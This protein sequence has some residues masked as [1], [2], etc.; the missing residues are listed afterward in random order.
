MK[1]MFIYESLSNYKKELIYHEVKTYVKKFLLERGFVYD[2]SDFHSLV[3]EIIV[4][5]AVIN[6]LIGDKVKYFNIK[7]I[8]VSSMALEIAYKLEKNRPSIEQLERY[9]ELC[10][11]HGANPSIEMFFQ[12]DIIQKKIELLEK[13]GL[14]VQEGEVDPIDIE[15]DV[16]QDIISNNITSFEDAINKMKKAI[17]S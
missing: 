2:D 1:M 10:K 13:H 11:S 14:Q 8:V 15:D 6:L 17:S 9:L 3:Y 5:G 7:E 16:K 4:H 12:K